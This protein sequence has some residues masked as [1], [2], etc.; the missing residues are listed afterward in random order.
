MPLLFR[1]K[2][3]G[4]TKMKK[5]L[6]FILAL[7][8]ILLTAASLAETLNVFNWGDYIDTDTL[9]QFEEETGID[10]VYQLYETNED[11]YAKMKS[12]SF[13]VIFPS[14]YMVERLIRE[15]RVQ[16]INWD[17]I[18]NIKNIDPRFLDRSYDPG[19][20]YSVPYTWGTMGILFNTSMVEE[21][22][23]SWQTL[24]DPAY[25]MDMLMLNSPRDTLG[26]AL[27]MTGHDLNSTDPADI[28]DAKQLLIEQKPMVLAYVVDEVKDKMIAG[29]AA[30]A[31]VWSGDA[32]Y[33][34]D[35]NDELDY[36]VPKEGSNIFFDA[37]CIPSDAKNVSGAEKFIDFLCRADIAAKN[38][39]YVGYAIPNTAAIEELGAEEYNSSPVNNPP[40]EALDRCEVF[41]YL[42]QE[43]QELYD[44]AWTE[45]I[46]DF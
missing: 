9:R 23:T 17:N 36:V 32:T 43:E 13:D 12:S 29:E 26:I 25:T 34:M 37:I 6:T 16:E 18:P 40:Q 4:E 46:S 41:R 30:V 24:M 22:P 31:L 7:S 3:K 35:E 1:Y 21:E 44:R 27:I 14:D 15:K 20:K 2:Q 42:P 8:L 39:E 5:I 33:C 45:I 19:S 10:V 28:E 11:M 38:Y